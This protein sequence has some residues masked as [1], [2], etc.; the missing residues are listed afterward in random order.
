MLI[1]LIQPAGKRRAG[2]LSSNLL[3]CL[4]LVGGFLALTACTPLGP[5]YEEPDVA[6]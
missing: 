6:W 3:P 4:A 1:E 5:D 2:R